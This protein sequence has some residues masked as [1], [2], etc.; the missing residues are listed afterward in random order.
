MEVDSIV[1]M[2]LWPI[3]LEVVYG[4]RIFSNVANGFDEPKGTILVLTSMHV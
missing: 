3:E 2:E 4:T 1:A